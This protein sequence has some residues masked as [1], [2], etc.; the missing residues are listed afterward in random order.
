MSFS[1]KCTRCTETHHGV[2]CFG[3]MA[4]LSYY[5]VPEGERE[6][7][8]DLSSDACVIDQEHFF[9]RGC[10]EIPV[11]GEAEPLS[12]GVW[13]SLNEADFKEWITTFDE[14]KRSDSGPYAGRLDAWLKPY[15][16][17][18]GLR[19]MVRLRDD[20]MRPYIELEP[21]DHP[22]A[23]EQRE[24]ISVARVADIYSI[25]MHPDE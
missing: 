12:W 18:M 23:V 15:P 14:A 9:V 24:G 5:E 4:P 25:M 11:E 8:C 1:F 3:A 10:L 7:R 13:V 17:T 21:T 20:G 22:L 2:P 16:D 19:T 6:S